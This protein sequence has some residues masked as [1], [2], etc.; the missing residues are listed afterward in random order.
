M[1]EQCREFRRQVR[2]LDP[3]GSVVDVLV[4]E[5]HTSCVVGELTS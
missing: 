5:D 4:V 2:E 3:F 1:D